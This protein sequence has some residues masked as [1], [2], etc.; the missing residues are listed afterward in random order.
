LGPTSLLQ[1]TTFDVSIEHFLSIRKVSII[2]IYISMYFFPHSK[3]LDNNTRRSDWLLPYYHNTIVCSLPLH[4][5]LYS[6]LI[7]IIF[8][9]N[10]RPAIWPLVRWESSYAIVY[11]I[12]CYCL[13]YLAVEHSYTTIFV[14]R[15]DARKRSFKCPTWLT[16]IK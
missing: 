14:L 4:Y 1:L 7:I 2:Y 8:V 6:D 5:Y 3:M 9:E 16:R 11:R 12:S 10:W 15:M 13:L